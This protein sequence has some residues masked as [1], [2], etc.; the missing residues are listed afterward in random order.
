MPDGIP[1]PTPLPD[2]YSFDLE[3]AL[4]RA[5]HAILALRHRDIPG[6]LLDDAIENDDALCQEYDDILKS[7]H[8]TTHLSRQ[9][10][11]PMFISFGLSRRE[12]E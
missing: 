7:L 6:A 4:H 8:Q 2:E 5:A 9:Q 11:N 12:S 1:P 3:S 10:I